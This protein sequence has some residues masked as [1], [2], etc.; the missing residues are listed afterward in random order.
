MLSA[1]ALA[2]LGARQYGGTPRLYFAC[3]LR[4]IWADW[5]NGKKTPDLP[6]A[7]C[8]ASGT[9]TCFPGSRYPSGCSADNAVCPA[10]ANKKGGSATCRLT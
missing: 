5:R 2:R 7:G 4:L 10:S 6:H 9:C 3:A 1:W 8:P